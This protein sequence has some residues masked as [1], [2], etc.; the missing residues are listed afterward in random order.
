MLNDE[1]FAW[2]SLCFKLLE[3]GRLV[4]FCEVA[5]TCLEEE[6]WPVV[7]DLRV[8]NRCGENAQLAVGGVD[9]LLQILLIDQS[10]SLFWVHAVQNIVL[11]LDIGS[12]SDQLLHHFLRGD[13]WHYCWEVLKD[14]LQVALIPFFFLLRAQLHSLSPV[15]R[16]FVCPR[17]VLLVLVFCF[18]QGQIWIEKRRS[19]CHLVSKIFV[20][21]SQL[22]WSIVKVI[23]YPEGGLL[24]LDAFL[25][26]H[27]E[28]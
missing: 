11:G 10:F 3:L 28:L 24:L 7:F 2:F 22:A 23:D 27:P 13:E 15:Y 1:S 9:R 25:N 6:I 17:Y 19:F 14:T 8:A 26:E 18:L 12:A 20:V 5:Q 21:L 16:N 4:L